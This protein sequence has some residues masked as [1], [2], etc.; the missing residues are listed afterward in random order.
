[1]TLRKGHNPG[2]GKIL[3]TG[4]T[5]NVGGA[6][7]TN[8]V[9]MGAAVRAL[10]RDESKA[11]GLKHAGVEVV[12]GELEKPE[13]LDAAFSGVDKVFLL[14]PVSPNAVTQASN[15]IAAARRAGRLY[16]VR[17]SA[18]KA[19]HQSPSRISRLHADTED[20]LKASGLPYTILKPHFFMQN[21]MMAAQ[22]V[23]SEGRVFMPVKNGKLGII[24]IRDIGEVAAKVLTS[25]GHQGNTYTLTGPASISFHDV[26]AGLSKAL[27]KEVKYVDVPLEAGRDAMLGMGFP[28]WVADGYIEYFKAYSEG[29]GDLVTADVEEIIGRAPRSYETFARDFAQVFGGAVLLAA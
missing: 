20:E 6:V 15:G 4:A 27:G 5:G 19:S 10:V 24:D 26:A 23:A 12:V 14:T 3:V 13:T 22:S 2:S 9:S 29:Y 11:Q 18:V 21:T 25:E 17:M 8:L 28:E 16:I 1:M 7:I